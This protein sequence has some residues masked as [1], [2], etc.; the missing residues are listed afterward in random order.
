M[1]FTGDESVSKTLAAQEPTKAADSR[2]LSM[3]YIF[4]GSVSHK[5]GAAMSRLRQGD[6]PLLLT[7]T[8]ARPRQ[9]APIVF[10]LP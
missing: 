9:R 3:T 5:A 8:S 6:D 1:A 10:A 4:G 2:L 7:D